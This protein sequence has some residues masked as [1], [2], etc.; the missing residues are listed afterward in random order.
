MAE[1][2][3]VLKGVTEILEQSFG[4]KVIDK[5]IDENMP[6]PCFILDTENI[7]REYFGLM[8]HIS[9]YLHIY[10][11]APERYTGYSK[12]YEAAD[13]IKSLFK[14]RIFLTNDFCIT[15]E[16]QKIEISRADMGLD[17]YGL[18]DIVNPYEEEEGLTE[19]LELDVDISKEA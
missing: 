2:K 16:E 14:G 11:M 13:S 6:R 3:D 12:L 15:I 7:E 18:V 8:E 19:M 4:L 10:Y 9:F 5:D 1:I 17:F